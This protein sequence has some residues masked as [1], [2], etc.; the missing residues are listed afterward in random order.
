MGSILRSGLCVCVPAFVH[1]PQVNTGEGG[2]TLVPLA[3]VRRAPRGE[4]L[5]ADLGNP[6]T[7]LAVQRQI[8]AVEACVPHATCREKKVREFSGG[9]ASRDFYLTGEQIKHRF[10][11]LLD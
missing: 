1:S 7:R 8:A 4:A 10:L 5:N 2:A 3:G 9:R 6:I 11:I